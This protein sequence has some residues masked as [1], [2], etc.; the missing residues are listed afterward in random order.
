MPYKITFRQTGWRTNSLRGY[1]R[2]K[3]GHVLSEKAAEFT[4]PL[5]KRTSTREV[6]KVLIWL[7]LVVLALSLNDFWL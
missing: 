1:S 2:P 3:F 5:A 4:A 6:L 7:V